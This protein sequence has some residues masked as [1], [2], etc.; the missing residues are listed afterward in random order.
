MAIEKARKYGMGMACE[1]T[2]HY[3]IAGYYASMA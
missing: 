1:E 2:T 3:G